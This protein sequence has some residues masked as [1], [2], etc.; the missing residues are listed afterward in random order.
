VMVS[1]LM[2]AETS[3]GLLFSVRPECAGDVREGFRA[4][5]EEVW[6][7][8]EVVSAPVLRLRG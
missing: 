5:G 1:L 2:E 8:G 7:I 3:G 4:A 6:E